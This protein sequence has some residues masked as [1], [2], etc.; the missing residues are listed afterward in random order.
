MKRNIGITVATLVAFAFTILSWSSTEFQLQQL[1]TADGLA[2]NTVRKIIQ[3][4]YGC[5][6]AA[7]SNG[8]SRYDGRMF[9][10]Y[11]VVHDKSRL[12]LTDQRVMNIIEDSERRLWIYLRNNDVVC[13]DLRTDRFIDFKTRHISV[14]V[15]N[16]T[17][18]ATMATDSK[19]RIW[20][21]TGNDGLYIKDTSAGTSEHFTTQS[22]TNPLPTNSLKCIFIDS[23]GVVWI[24]TDNL[25]ISRLRVIENDGVEYMLDG[26]NIRMLL[27]LGDSHIAVGNRNGTVWI[28]DS[29]LTTCQNTMH[30]NFNTYYLAMA[31]D[32]TGWRGTKGD[33]LYVGN[34]HTAHYLHNDSVVGSLSH[35]EIYAIHFDSDGHTWVGTFGG[36]LCLAESVNAGETL[37]FTTFLDH[38]YGSRR[39]RAIV[40]DSLSMLWIATSNGVYRLDPRL[41]KA[42]TTIY[43]HLSTYNSTL[44]NDEVRTLLRASDGSIYISEAGE[45]FA[46][47]N[48]NAHLIRRVTELG[49]SLVNSMVQCFVEDDDGMIWVSTEFGVSRYNPA[50]GHISNYFMSKNMLN[51]VYSENCGMRLADGRI[52]FGTNNGVAIITPHIF[53]QGEPTSGIDRTEVTIG[54]QAPRRDIIYIVSQWWDSPW[55]I[56]SYITIAVALLVWW[57]RV[58][59]NNRRFYHAI[60]T[61]KT[62]KEVMRERFTQDVKLRRKANTDASEA[63]FIKR[64]DDIVAS[65]IDNPEFTSDNFAEH[66]NMGRTTFF[67]RMKTITGYTPREYLNLKRM[68][69]AAELLTTTTL[70]IGEISDRVGINDQL[71]LSRMFRKQYGCSPSKWR[72][73][74]TR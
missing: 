6:W 41:F 60:A 27:P 55:A 38:D 19:G 34:E 31:P 18:S 35:N 17:T 3:D 42:D 50:T 57:M 36:G 11:R 30:Y 4:S 73:Q 65:E 63:E 25:G 15:T 9:V 20:Q 61:L 37:R 21:V 70:S 1:T 28:Y 72:K 68:K 46:I 62:Q 69:R 58:R 56:A 10:N 71:Y 54:G 48:S 53:N 49:D 66:M 43:T 26:E 47:F 40:E 52:A 51:N 14:P 16:G 64:A 45:G 32:G 23:E 39:I 5:I 29:M 7:T 12:G 59:R 74:V 24:G 22:H 8:L 44:L 67:V 2:N 33:G 13:L